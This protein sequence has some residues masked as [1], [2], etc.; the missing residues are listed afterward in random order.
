M[1]GLNPMAFQQGLNPYARQQGLQAPM[2]AMQQNLR[3]GFGGMSPMGMMG[4]GAHLLQPQDPRKP[5]NL[6][7]QLGGA[8]PYMMMGR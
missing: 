4:L 6:M 3:Q 7:A 2:G 8:L 5:R 1:L